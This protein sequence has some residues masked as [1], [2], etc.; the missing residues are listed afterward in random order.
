MSTAW[1]LETDDQVLGIGFSNF[2]FILKSAS[3]PSLAGKIVLFQFGVKK[4]LSESAK[5]KIGIYCA[6]RY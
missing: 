1:T 3:V 6:S 2:I 4:R 5:P